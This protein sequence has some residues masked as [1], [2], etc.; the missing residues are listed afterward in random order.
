LLGIAALLGASVAIGFTVG[1]LFRRHPALDPTSPRS[2]R[3]A[4]RAVARAE[5]GGEMARFFV[6]SLN[7]AEATGLALTLVFAAIVVVFV[8]GFEVRASGPVVRFDRAVSDW[9]GRNVD[10]S[11]YDVADAITQLGSTVGVILIGVVVAAIETVRTRSRW[12]VPFLALTLVGQS[13]ASNLI[14]AGVG[15]FRPGIDPVIGLGTDSFPSGHSAAAASTIAAAAF[16]MSRRHTPLVKSVLTGAGVGIAVA[17]GISRV[18]LTYHWPSDV[19]AGLMLGWG[20]FGV[21]AIAFGGRLLV[22]GAPIEAGRRLGGLEEH[23]AQT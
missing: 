22:F 10:G 1:R 18:L 15:R 23:A 7:P 4:A 8:L 17:V 9:A 11:S 14:K 2:G 3:R 19:V 21:C 12:I 20:W 13:I 6:R 16:L 5:Q